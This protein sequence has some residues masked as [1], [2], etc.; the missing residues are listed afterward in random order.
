[1][2][3]K[4]CDEKSLNMVEADRSLWR[5]RMLLEDGLTYKQIC[6][7]LNDEKILTIKGRPW[8][9]QN[10]KIL[11]FRLRHKASSFYAR[12]QRKAG[13]VIEPLEVAA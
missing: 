5:I 11:I 9:P 7:V 3:K 13:L 2:D 4:W 6:Q 1:M 10:L 12:S 8:S